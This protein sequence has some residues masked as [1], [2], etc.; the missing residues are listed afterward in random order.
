[1]QPAGRAHVQ[2]CEWRASYPCNGSCAWWFIR[3]TEGGMRG[4]ARG[5]RKGNTRE[6]RRSSVAATADP[7]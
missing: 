3:G 7:R 5:V 4:W 6:E 1:M 2:G